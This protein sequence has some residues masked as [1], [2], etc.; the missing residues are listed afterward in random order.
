MKPAAVD[1]GEGGR[2]V[3]QVQGSVSERKIFKAILEAPIL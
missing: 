3:D 2:E 1:T